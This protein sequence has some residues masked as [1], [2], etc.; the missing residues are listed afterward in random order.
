MAVS[1]L[2]LLR[3]RCARSVFGTAVRDLN[4]LDPRRYERSDV[5]PL[6]WTWTI[7]DHDVRVQKFSV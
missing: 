6:W 1:V 4:V 5:P 3:E 7:Y 2:V